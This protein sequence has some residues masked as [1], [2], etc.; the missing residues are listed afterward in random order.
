MDAAQID[1]LYVDIGRGHPFYLDGIRTCLNP[2]REGSVRDVFDVCRGPS[3]ALWQVARWLYGAGSSRGGDRPLYSRLRARADFRRPGLLLRLMGRPVA[4]AYG[5]ATNVLVVSHPLLV[6]MLGHHPR[7]VYQHGELAVPREALVPGSH[8][9]LV[10][11]ARAADVF[12]QAGFTRD[13]LVVTG[14]CVEPDLVRRAPKAY[15][16]RAVRLASASPLT[17]A[18][19][20]SGAEPRLHVLTLAEAALSALAAGGHAV[21]LARQR[22][23]YHAQVERA[24]GLR[25]QQLAVMDAEATDLPL[26]THP[27]TLFTYRTR[28][29]IERVT[30]RCFPAWDYVC[31]PAHERS[32]WALGLGMPLFALDPPIGSFAP[33][34]RARLL[35]EGVAAPLAPAA[36]A[37]FGPQLAEWQRAGVLSRMAAAGW[38][39]FTINGFARSSEFLKNVLART[40]ASTHSNAQAR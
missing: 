30:N 24:F 17:G 10:P 19:L 18:F 7:L 40:D 29:G 35:A 34:N 26:P 22:G 16:G 14:L 25:G 1:F 2:A 21:L 6:A 31:S 3:G 38:D 39:R 4:R 37:T 32:H 36:A 27:A 28:R 12:L 11:D 13:Q 23:Q 8:T 33:L 5:R 15:H 20:S 9:V